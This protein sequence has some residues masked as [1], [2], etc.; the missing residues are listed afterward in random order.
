MKRVMLVVVLVCACGARSEIAGSDLFGDGS[1]SFL[2]AT[3]KQDGSGGNDASFGGNDGSTT[4]HDSGCPGP[5]LATGCAGPPP[6]DCAA[7]GCKFDLESDCNGNTF[8]VGGACQPTDGGTPGF[9]E[10][11]CQ[12]NGKTTSTFDVPTT[13]CDC[14]DASAFLTL[15][16]EKC[17]HQ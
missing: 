14:K 8:R 16:Q 10:G 6:G 3:T 7:W 12:E 4:Q 15:V 17:Q 5:T 13:T 11:V 2:D 9:Y 1:V